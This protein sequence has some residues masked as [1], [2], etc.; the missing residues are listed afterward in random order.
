MNQRFVIGRH[1][2]LTMLVIGTCA[3]G[4]QPRTIE[5]L[6]EFSDYC[7]SLNLQM[8]FP[9]AIDEF[10]VVDPSR[11]ADAATVIRACLPNLY[12]P[13]AQGFAMK[14][15]P[16]SFDVMKQALGDDYDSF[17]D[18]LSPESRGRI[19]TAIGQDNVDQQSSYD[20]V[21]T[22]SYLLGCADRYAKS[23]CLH[24]SLVVYS[25]YVVDSVVSLEN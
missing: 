2:V 13:T 19:V 23:N 9:A 4:D 11:K 15:V 12:Y 7:N 24:F 16:V 20:S 10:S 6:S 3:R 1:L 21:T 14:V 8:D 25:N 22:I 18:K 5:T 17:S